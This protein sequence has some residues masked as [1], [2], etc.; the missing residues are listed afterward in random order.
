MYSQL[1]QDEWVLGLYGKDTGCFVDVGFNDGIVYSNT[2][3]LEKKGWI[4]LGIDPFPQNYSNRPRT[5]ICNSLVYDQPNITVDFCISDVYSGILTEIG[6]HKEKT[7][8]KPIVQLKTKT[9]ES[10]LDESSFPK[11]IEYLS[12]D[13]E[14]SEY[15]IINSFNFK[16]YSFG[17]ITVEHNFENEKREQ[18]I[19]KLADNGYE[20]YKQVRFD[21]WYINTS[22]KNYFNKKKLT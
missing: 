18:V 13:T 12:L 3:L 1:G 6:R 9:L 10:I 14:G 7:V 16:K 22:M 11:F 2:Y 8:G 15:K 20:L 17:C 4:G 19:K 5:I 21:D